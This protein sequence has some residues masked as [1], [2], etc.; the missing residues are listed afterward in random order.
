MFL[1]RPKI[2]L[3]DEPTA[4]IDKQTEIKIIQALSTHMRE[5]DTLVMTTHKFELLPLVDRLIMVNN[6]EIV[7][8]G[9]KDQVI[10]HLQ[11]PQSVTPLR[12]YK[13]TA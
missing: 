8:D 5:S 2:W 11:N 9:P 10:A 6:H 12:G 4:S 1:R 13:K 7:F 3:L